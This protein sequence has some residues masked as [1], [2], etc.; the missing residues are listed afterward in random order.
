M[1]NYILKFRKNVNF[2]NNHI[3]TTT[4]FDIT[5]NY[6]NI[7]TS[8]EQYRWSFFSIR[9]NNNTKDVILVQS[10][11]QYP[12][13]KIFYPLN[14]QR[15]EI[16]PNA[17]L[18]IKE[19]I[20]YVDN[21]KSLFLYCS[22]TSD[23]FITTVLSHIDYSMPY[24]SIINTEKSSENEFTCL[25]QNKSP[26]I[27]TFITNMMN[28]FQNDNSNINFIYFNNSDHDVQICLYVL[29]Q[30][31]TYEE[32]YKIINTVTISSECYLLF[33]TDT[34]ILNENDGLYLWTDSNDK[35]LCIFN[36]ETV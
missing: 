26:N 34:I 12:N 10:G 5:A 27:I 9:V 6:T 11:F 2:N 19:P 8:D 28:D 18:F 21:G 36:I 30:N 17:I 32:K 33:D 29:R 15:Y 16:Q 25:Y 23:I 31:Q 35:Y 1:E 13:D 14:P 24:Y 7:C 3:L 22:H 20:I 4:S